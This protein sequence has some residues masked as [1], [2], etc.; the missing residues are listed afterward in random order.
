MGH[1][2]ICQS[3]WIARKIGRHQRSTNDQRRS[4]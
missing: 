3:C 2:W 4:N 1:K